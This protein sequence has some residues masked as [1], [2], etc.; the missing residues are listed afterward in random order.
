MRRSD[1]HV[2]ELF[3]E[4][5]E[6]L[7]RIA[8][9]MLGDAGAAEEVVQDAFVKVCSRW[10]LFRSVENRPAYLRTVV[11]NECRSRLRRSKIETRVNTIA[12]GD[13][14]RP[15]WDASRSDAD[16]DLWAAIQQLPPRMRASIVLRYLEDMPDAEIARVLDCSV[17]TV[18]SQLSR[19]RE[20]LA[21][22]LAPHPEGG[23][24]A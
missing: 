2:A 20:R 17:G 23:E 1:G 15:G 13:R 12:A 8:F 6:A 18:K 24:P 10:G 9:A 11:I 4:H 5:H 19:A 22:V 3:D 16:L 21:R 14:G 7:R